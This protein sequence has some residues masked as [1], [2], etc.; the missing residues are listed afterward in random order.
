MKIGGWRT[1]SVFEHY[2]IV[3]QNDIAAAMKKLQASEQAAAKSYSSVTLESKSGS[4]SVW[5]FTEL[6]IRSCLWETVHM[7]GKPTLT[8]NGDIYG[9]SVCKDWTATMD[10]KRGK[11]TLAQRQK[12]AERYFAVH[13]KQRHSAD[14]DAIPKQ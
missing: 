7:A 2:A 13:L 5:I 10:T 8:K 9:C 1:R 3:D 11:R 6:V 12:Q 14:E 4:V